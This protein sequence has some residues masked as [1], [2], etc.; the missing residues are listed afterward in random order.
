MVR[1]FQ[2]RQ[3]NIFNEAVK[4]Q[5]RLLPAEI[6]GKL[7]PVNYNMSRKRVR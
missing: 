5:I 6:E 4:T 7:S 3:A 1:L 2:R